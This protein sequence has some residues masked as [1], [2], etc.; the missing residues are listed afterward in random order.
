MRLARTTGTLLLALGSACSPYSTWDAPLPPDCTAESG[1][2]LKMIDDCE[3]TVNWWTSAD[4]TGHREAGVDLPRCSSATA[5][6]EPLTNGGRCGS[7]AAA[8]FRAANNND[9]GALAGFNGFGPRDASQWEGLAFWARA[10]GNVTRSFTIL[11]DDANTYSYDVNS[12]KPTGIN[13]AIYDTGTGTTGGSGSTIDPSSGQVYTAGGTTRAPYPDEC[14]NGYT[15]IVQI[16]PG[17]RF[18][19]IPWA[20]FY[21]TAT[22]NRVPNEKLTERGTVP[23]TALITSKLY[24]LGLRF[25]KE[26]PTELWIDNLAFYGKKAAADGGTQ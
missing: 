14:G 23:G 19:T 8:V 21:Q 15:A 13:C 6:I 24:N 4:G 10:P 16:T 20:K 5:A 25:Q 9:W 7:A 18:Y 11:L 22:P 17:W 3:T 26:M 1:Y 12:P 2:D